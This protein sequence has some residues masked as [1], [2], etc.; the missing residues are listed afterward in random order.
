MKKQKSVSLIKVMDER[1]IKE[2]FL[3]QLKNALK[4]LFGIITQLKKKNTPPPR[5]LSFA[6]MKEADEIE[7]FLDEFGAN[8]NKKFFPIREMIAGIRWFNFFLF[9]GLHLYTRV[10]HYKLMITKKEYL[11][12]RKDLYKNLLYGYR[13]IKKIGDKLLKECESIGIK[14]KKGEIYSEKLFP[15][16]QRKILPPDLDEGLLKEKEER[17]IEI[18]IKYLNVCEEF[19][20]FICYRHAD[21]LKEEAIEKYRS[22]FG[23][24]ESLY[25]TYIKNT[26]YEMEINEFKKV[27]GHIAVSL[28]LLEMAKALA[29]F[30]ERHIEKITY[31]DGYF[32]IIECIGDEN[33]IKETI[34]KFLIPYV[35]RFS[36]KGKEICEIIF[37]KI[38]RNPE[39]FLIET[40]VLLIPSH[41]LE[42]FHIRP[43]MPVTQIANKYSLDS[44]LYFNRRKY[45]LRD[46]IEM[47]MAIPDIREALMKENVQIL[48]Q[49]PLSAI[50]EIVE[51]FK[52]KC[53][54]IEKNLKCEISVS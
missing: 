25:D 19:N 39:E 33:K 4:N 38:N 8:Q 27:R 45:K 21:F 43:I 16:L 42:D 22:L 48:I 1:E 34:E 46:S 3:P 7:T 18:L 44:Y 11:T 23:Q 32:K 31:S 15:S 41:R 12:F 6:L 30:Y 53:G 37:N 47:A 50:K 54:A 35:L 49:G 17:I 5:E 10:K 52:E 24:L 14:T 29:H 51:F 40:R 13:V 2:E 9:Q 26:T 28:H 36:Q 20:L